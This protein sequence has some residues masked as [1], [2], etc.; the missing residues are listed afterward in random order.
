M[1]EN[2]STPPFDGASSKGRHVF[3][4]KGHAGN[5]IALSPSSFPLIAL[6]GCNSVGKKEEEK[7]IL[8]S[9]GEGGAWEKGKE[10][11]GGGFKGRQKFSPLATVVPALR[12]RIKGRGG[13]GVEPTRRL[14][15]KRRKELFEF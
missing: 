4:S 2:L 12:T 7:G 6:G 15:R 8:G 1:E 10:K 11:L 13:G 5:P 9:G 3:Y 14:E